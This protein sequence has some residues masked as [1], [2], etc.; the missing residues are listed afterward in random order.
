M[1][2]LT[3]INTRFKNLFYLQKA[4]NKLNVTYKTKKKWISDSKSY[5]TDLVV[6][7]S[8]GYDITFSWN[9]Q[10]YDLISDFM[11]WQQPIALETFTNKLSQKY[12]KQVIV[13]ESEKIGFQLTQYQKNSDGSQKLILERWEN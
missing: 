8:N 4:L 10:N 3:Y 1:S 9:G 6:S 12:A 13:G 5:C 2:H 11:F 7:Q